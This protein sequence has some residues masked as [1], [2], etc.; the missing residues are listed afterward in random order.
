MYCGCEWEGEMG[1]RGRAVG[2]IEKGLFNRGPNVG[3]IRFP[4]TP[5]PAF[6]RLHSFSQ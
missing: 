2:L 5:L 1:G 4:I 3:L 6:R